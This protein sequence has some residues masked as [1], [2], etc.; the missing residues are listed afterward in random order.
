[1]LPHYVWQDFLD[2]LGDLLQNGF[3]LEP[4]WFA[5]QLEFR[6]PFCGD[7]EYEGMKL[8]LNQALEPWLVMGEQGA[9][10]GTVRF[11]DSSVE[12][13]QV[14]LEGLNPERYAVT[15]N[16]RPVP[17]RGTGEAGVAVAGVR[18]KAWQP[19]S[20]MH[21]KLPVN[22]PLVFDLYDLWSGRSVGG[23]IYHVAHP[24]GRSYDTFPVNGNEAEARRLARFE[25]RG[26]TAGGFSFRPEAPSDE[27]PL[28]LDLRRPVE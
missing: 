1:M 15:C 26:Y 12:R 10:G 28:T 21:P 6:F 3:E 19:A 13:L 7:V 27:F 20:G 16:R 2:V 8:T 22:A 23:C 25:P 9:I 24:G 5:A 17:L 4:E 18:Y 11:V 14:K